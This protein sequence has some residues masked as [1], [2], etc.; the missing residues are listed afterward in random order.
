MGGNTLNPRLDLSQV[1]IEDAIWGAFD[2]NETPEG[3]DFWLKVPRGETPELP[4]HLN[5]EV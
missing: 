1:N 5:E 4:E 2:W 3:H